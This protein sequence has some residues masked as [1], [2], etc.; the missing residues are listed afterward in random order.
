VLN[1]QIRLLLIALRTWSRVL[2][3]PGTPSGADIARS[4]R[5]A[6]VVGLIV[7]VAASLVYAFAGAWLPHPLALLA[8]FA[9]AMLLTASMHERG[10][11]A[12]CDGNA[13]A[14]GK[15]H[16][17]AA[18][19]ALGLAMLLLTRFETLVVL[20]PSWI[21]IT[22]LCGAALSRGCA[23]L[24]NA[25]LPAPDAMPVSEAPAPG[26]L[27]LAVA[28]GCGVAP[29]VAAIVWTGD[30]GVF[31]TGLAAAV[32][33]ALL[34]RRLCVRRLGGRSDAGFGAAQQA[35]ELAFHLGIVATLALVDE[36]PLDPAP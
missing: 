9:T 34:M 1:L 36:T 15:M 31:L 4:A 20:D 22:L 3:D 30:A 12:L 10:F 8:A 33:T 6:P 21:P 32:L 28:A 13:D 7:A 26:G 27:E 14:V 23:V 2:G 5:Y 25:T 24:V 35:C 11:A 19:G 29:L 16:A 17:L 18:G